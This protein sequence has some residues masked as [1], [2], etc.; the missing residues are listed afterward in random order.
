MYLCNTTRTY[1][2]LY[3]IDIWSLWVEVEREAVRD[4]SI[5]HPSPKPIGRDQLVRVVGSK[6][7]TN[8]LDGMNIFIVLQKNLMEDGIF[9]YE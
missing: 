5:R 6:N 3:S 4:L 8:S 7:T 9:K 1:T 2:H